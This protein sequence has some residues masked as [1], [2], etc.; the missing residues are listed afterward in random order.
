MKYPLFYVGFQLKLKHGDKCYW[1]Y[2]ISISTKIRLT[3]IELLH[4]QRQTDRQTDRQ[5]AFLAGSLQRV[6]LRQQY[7]L[8]TVMSVSSANTWSVERQVSRYHS[9]GPTPSHNKHYMNIPV[10]SWQRTQ[11]PLMRIR[12]TLH[13]ATSLLMMAAV[14]SHSAPSSG[15]C[16]SNL[17]CF[18]YDIDPTHWKTRWERDIEREEEKRTRTW[19]PLSGGVSGG[20]VDRTASKRVR[21]RSPRQ[22]RFT[23]LAASILFKNFIFSGAFA[24]Q[25]RHACPSIVRLSVRWELLFQ[26]CD[27]RQ[28]NFR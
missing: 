19:E 8:R 26:H 2:A 5:T 22:R 23:S 27:S 17:C 6:G 14:T 21:Q 18:G 20:H 15:S 24:N 7:Q 9:I 25:S 11:R 10:L 4:L 13:E 3:F 16:W 1:N 28:K 12:A